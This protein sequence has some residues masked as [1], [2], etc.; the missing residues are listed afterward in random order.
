[1]IPM[2]LWWILGVLNATAFVLAVV[3]KRRAR[4]GQHRIRE[5]SLLGVAF[6]GGS[7]GLLVGM[8]LVRHK[9][10]KPTFLV[11]LFAIVVVQSALVA[12]LYVL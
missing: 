2:W 12:W 9:V 6:V 11:R 5:R 10:R 8:V 4:R 3:D 7:L 1:M